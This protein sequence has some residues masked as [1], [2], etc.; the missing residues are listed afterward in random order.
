LILLSPWG[1]VDAALKSF[2]TFLLGLV[3]VT[4]FINPWAGLVLS[5]IIILLAYL[6]AGWSFRLTTCGTI[7]VWD[8]IT[9]RKHRFSPKPDGNWMFTGRK[10]NKVPVRTYGRL[11]RA[12][13]GELNFVY[14]RWLFFGKP[15]TLVLPAGQ[16]AVGRGA[17][18][19]EVLLVEGEKEKTMLSLP[20]RY[21]THEEEL[22]RVYGLLGVR[23]IG[24]RKMW[25]W[26]KSLFSGSEP[27]TATA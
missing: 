15:Q 9:G 12:P 23:P 5:L 21:R 20:P 10:L 2:R 16:Y 22:A 8:F 1:V 4:H 14:R 6:L 3:T 18:Y 25:R 11:L 19:S 7:Y 26:L 17:I 27:A 13:N 24:L